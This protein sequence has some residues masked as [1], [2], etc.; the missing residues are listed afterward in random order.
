MAGAPKIGLPWSF[1]AQTGLPRD[2]EQ[3]LAMLTEL[4]Q[5]G[6]GDSLEDLDLAEDAKRGE[7]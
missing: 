4:G 7:D 3:A 6:S 5:H 1:G 2:K